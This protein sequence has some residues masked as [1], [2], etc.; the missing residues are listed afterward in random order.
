MVLFLII[1]GSFQN[2]LWFRITFKSLMLVSHLPSTGQEGDLS[3]KCHFSIRFGKADAAFWD[4][5]FKENVSGVS[6]KEA[7]VLLSA[8]YRKQVLA[9]WGCCWPFHHSKSCFKQ[10]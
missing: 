7:E 6:G 10:L 3:L 8:M 4:V 9:K 1:N 2:K 5:Q